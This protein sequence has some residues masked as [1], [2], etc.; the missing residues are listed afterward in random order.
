M[1]NIVQSLYQY[2]KILVLII[3]SY[4]VYIE[5]LMRNT[6][7]NPVFYKMIYISFTF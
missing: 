4:G 2:Y 1:G 7:G 6:H 5:L 3:Q